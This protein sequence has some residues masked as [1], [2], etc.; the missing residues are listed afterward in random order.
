[1]ILAGSD[2]QPASRAGIMG[3]VVPDTRATS[4]IGG[5]GGRSPSSVGH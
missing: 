2:T 4:F 1:M 5:D 3:I